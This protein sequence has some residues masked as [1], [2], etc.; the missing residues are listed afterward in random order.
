MAVHRAK[1]EFETEYGKNLL[2]SLGI[3]EEY[4]GIGNLVLGYSDMDAKV[5]PRKENWVYDVK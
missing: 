3:N 5:K 1:E 4:E 2:K